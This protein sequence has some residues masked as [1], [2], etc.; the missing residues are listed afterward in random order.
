MQ[1]ITAWQKR[2][3]SSTCVLLQKENGVSDTNQ[4]QWIYETCCLYM[5]ILWW[6]LS[7]CND[8][9]VSTD[10]ATACL[11]NNGFVSEEDYEL[12]G[13]CEE[14]NHCGGA[15]PWLN[16]LHMQTIV[17]F[18]KLKFWRLLLTKLFP[19][20]ANVVVGYLLVE[21]GVIMVYIRV[22]VCRSLCH[23]CVYSGLHI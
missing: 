16:N 14:P 5:R 3:H 1:T 12:Q 18:V 8:I 2:G 17:D 7:C 13:W 23:C 10:W 21:A 20:I 19:Y 15:C 4:P 9:V 11:E 6:I 22:F